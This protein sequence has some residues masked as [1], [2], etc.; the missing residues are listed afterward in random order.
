MVRS[1]QY[2]ATGYDPSY[3]PQRGDIVTIDFDPHQRGVEIQK[4]RP[5][6]VLS[7]RDFN[8]SQNVSVVC[9]ITHTKITHDKKKK[10]Q[11]KI[12]GG[13]KTIGFIQTDKIKCFDWRERQAVLFDEMPYC[14]VDKVVEK[15][16][17]D[18]VW[19]NEDHRHYIPVRGNVVEIDDDS[20]GRCRALVLSPPSFNYWQQKFLICKII[21]PRNGIIFPGNFAVKIPAEFDA[22]RV[23]LGDI[24]LGDQV[25]SW[26]WWD[27]KTEHLGYLPDETVAEVCAKVEA[28]MYGD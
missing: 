23:I 10:Y 21:T 12:P 26:D 2:T 5:A 11:V 6:L 9:A 13:L 25:K 18:I 1:V 3:I 15:I 14:T 24:I 8:I 27:R 28:I 19:K 4:R 17:E 22:E 20:N 16:V 7:T